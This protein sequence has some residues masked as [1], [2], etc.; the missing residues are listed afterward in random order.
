[1]W[2]KKDFR[3][4]GRD[5]VGEL[6]VIEDS[7]VGFSFTKVINPTITREKTDFVLEAKEALVKYANG[8]ISKTTKDT[9][10]EGIITNLNK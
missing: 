6:T 10:V 1:M 5:E 4:I 3:L 7:F 8:E 9:V 2:K